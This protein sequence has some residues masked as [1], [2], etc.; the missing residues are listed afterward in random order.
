M[1]NDY[2]FPLVA[3]VILAGVLTACLTATAPSQ[4]QTPPVAAV[5]L[6]AGN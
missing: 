6:S 2:S 5:S 4:V 1:K 3:A